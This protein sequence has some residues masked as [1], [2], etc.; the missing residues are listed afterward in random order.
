MRRQIFAATLALSLVTAIAS[1]GASLRFEKVSNHCYYLRLS[2]GAANVIAVVTEDGILIMDPPPEPDLTVMVEA[3]KRVS[4]KAVR[5]VV[6]SSPRSAVLE[7]ARYFAEKGAALLAGSQLYAL[8]SAAPGKAAPGGG[9]PVDLSSLQ[10]IVFN[11]QIQV[12]P[13]NLE[14]RV[15]AL[16][17][18]AQTGG[19]V[20]V[21]VPDEKVLFAGNFY[22]A[23]RYPEIDT[24]LKGNAGQWIDALK[25]VVDFVPLLKQAIVRTKPQPKTD[26]KEEP[27]K[28]LEEGITVISAQGEVSNFQ[29]MKDLLGVSQKLRADMSK[30]IKGGRSCESYL[31]SPRADAYRGYAN[32]DSFAA[33]L[34]KEMR[35]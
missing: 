16:Q 25:E 2:P 19:D 24:G 27:E 15:L 12:F 34:C 22:E 6:F 3:L 26:P 33:Q 35:E 10:W 13:A 8:A 30:A 17:H 29:N 14:I 4:P 18:R 9:P 32:F 1:S 28:T 11:K 23:G 31:A 7:G 5:W 20:V 21:F